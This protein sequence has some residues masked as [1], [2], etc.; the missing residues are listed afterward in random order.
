MK[1]NTDQGGF[2][3]LEVVLAMAILAI[4]SIPLLSYFTDSMKYNAMMADKQHATILAQD[5]VESLKLQQKLVKIS[6]S[7]TAYGVPYLLDNKYVID[8]SVPDT[9]YDDG[10]GEV[11]YYGAA[12]N[13][14]EKYDV[15]IHISTDTLENKEEVPQIYGIDDMRDVLAVDDGQF[16]EAL[17]YF[18]ALN[19]TYATQKKISP[20]SME[21][22][23]SNIERTIRVSIEKPAGTDYYNVI[24]ESQYEGKDMQGAGS[25]DLFNGNCEL[26]NV[27]LKDVHAIYLL[28]EVHQKSDKLEILRGTLVNATPELHVIC[29]NDT[30]SAPIPDDYVLNVDTAK[31]GY[32]PVIYTNLGNGNP[33]TIKDST[34][35][36]IVGPET[37]LVRNKKEIR[38]VDIRVSVY[39]KGKGL[40]TGEEPYIT[41][42]ASKG[43]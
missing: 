18:C 5:I 17:N 34:L 16:S 35:T 4:I 33:G 8:T 14:G 27:H 25:R 36:S 19:Q 37:K 43:E 9:L 26:A 10:V 6:D 22:V 28:Y 15:K 11:Q 31:S 24:A 32:T 2:S 12:D 1:Q 38:N 21:D 23:K 40:S 41:V 3:L 20:M 30:A 13:I 39:K 7:G 42:K 29:Q